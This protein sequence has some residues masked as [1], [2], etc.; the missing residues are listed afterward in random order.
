MKAIALMCV[1]ITERRAR[2]EPLVIVRFRGVPVD[3]L[4]S[5]VSII[6]RVRSFYFH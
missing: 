5:C 1:I 3:L 4:T 2:R 6:L